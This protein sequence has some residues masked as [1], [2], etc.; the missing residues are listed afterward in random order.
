MKQ[1]SVIFGIMLVSAGG[2]VLSPSSVRAAESASY[3]LYDELPNS[4]QQGPSESEHFLLNND[5]LTWVALPIASTNFQMVSG[6]PSVSSSS[7]S[8]SSVATS[9]A[10]S[11]EAQNPQGG[12]RGEGTAYS[13]SSSVSSVPGGASSTSSVQ[14][15][16]SGASS[17][18]SSADVPAPF[19]PAPPLHPRVV[20]KAGGASQSSQRS[21]QVVEIAQGTP[22]PRS[23]GI[24]DYGEN[25]LFTDSPVSNATG[26]EKEVVCVYRLYLFKLP[27]LSLMGTWGGM[28]FILHLTDIL[29]ILLGFL[30]IVLGMAIKLRRDRQR[31]PQ[32]RKHRK[33][34]HRHKRT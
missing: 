34:S 33:S 29:L 31:P 16:P 28:E 12:G 25:C 6:A 18:S 10:A 11:S 2:M 26:S 23:P 3:L 4:A 8:F 9:S 22:Y 24:N 15:V 13:S 21:D 20:Q 17:E 32:N 5:G 30:T 14:S 19:H 27:D 1:I 7:S